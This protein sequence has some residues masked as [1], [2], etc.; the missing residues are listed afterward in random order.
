MGGESGLTNFVERAFFAGGTI[1]GSRD[2]LCLNEVA[3]GLECSESLLPKC[4]I[5]G[6]FTAAFARGV[7]NGPLGDVDGEHFLKAQSLRADLDVVIYPTAAFA[8]F[9]FDWNQR[10]VGMLFD[11]VAFSDETE[12][13][14]PNGQGTQQRDAF[15]DF[16]A[17]EVGVVVDNVAFSRVNVG[18]AHP[19]DKLQGSTPRTIKIVVEEREG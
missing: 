4:R 8:E 14:R 1:F 19:L 16:V 5:E 18:A 7:E 12:M 2:C 15:H 3:K 13:V 11:K 17:G 10:A 6:N 9:E